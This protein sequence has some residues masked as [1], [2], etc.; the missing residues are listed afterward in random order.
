MFASDDAQDVPDCSRL[1]GTGLRPRRRPWERGETGWHGGDI[2]A[3]SRY[4][5]AQR[6]V[7][8]HHG[9]CRR[10]RWIPL[11]LDSAFDLPMRRDG[12]HGAHSGW[13][14][15]QPRLAPLAYGSRRHDDPEPSHRSGELRARQRAE[16]KSREHKSPAQAVRLV[17]AEARAS[18]CRQHTTHART[19]ENPAPMPAKPAESQSRTARW[20]LRIAGARRA[21]ALDRPARA[22]NHPPCQ[23]RLRSHQESIPE[24]P[25]RNPARAESPHRV[26]DAAARA[27]SSVN[28]AMKAIRTSSP[29]DTAGR[30]SPRG[31]GV[32]TSDG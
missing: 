25:T 9:W 23:K 30:A 13:R 11:A 17:R 24:L 16:C 5:E 32:V 29:S 8:T 19:R 6:L 28:H 18:G 1:G 15:P 21:S 2:V 20:V 3:L 12:G 26:P 10:G 7:Q 14:L 22:R 27:G 4:L 31:A